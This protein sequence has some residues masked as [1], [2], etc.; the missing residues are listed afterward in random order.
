MEEIENFLVLEADINKRLDMFLLEKFPDRTRSFLK[1]LIEKEKVLVN[2]KL[3]KSGYKLKQNDNV[4]V[5]LPEP[6]LVDIVAENIPID[7]VYEDEHLAVI[8]KPQNM[9]VHPAGS[10]KSGTLV[11]ALMYHINSL[12]SINGEIRPGIVHR[13]DKDTSGLIV[14]AKDDKTHLALQKQ[15]QEKTCHRIYRAVTYGKFNQEEGT[16]QT[17]LARGR[18]QHEK[19]FVV[20]FGQGR[21]AITNYRVLNYNKG[22]SYVEYELKTGRTHQIRVHSSYLNHPIVG[23]KVY[24]KKGEKF[25][26]IGQLLHAYKLVFV[27]PV[28][29]EKMEFCAEI[30]D[31]FQKFLDN[32]F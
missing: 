27:H 19:I 24:G 13:L 3:V 23:D 18:S 15:I 4:S 16:I 14:I 29:Q 12:S 28:S 22:F 20:P 26:L 8:N 21:I 30:P 6:E 7:I 11:N 1:N 31:Y 9:V 10:L 2:D 17:C 5:V 25:N 32:H